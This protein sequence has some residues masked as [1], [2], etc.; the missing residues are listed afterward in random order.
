[1]EQAGLAY[2]ENEQTGVAQPTV[3]PTS[4]RGVS[5]DRVKCKKILKVA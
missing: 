1:M 4:Y 5:L 2:C 3:G